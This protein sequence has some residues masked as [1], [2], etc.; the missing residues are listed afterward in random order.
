[1]TS[2]KRNWTENRANSNNQTYPAM[3]FWWRTLFSLFSQCRMSDV[4]TQNQW[5]FQ[6]LTSMH[7]ENNSKFA[8]IDRFCWI[9][10]TSVEVEDTSNCLLAAK[11]ILSLSE[12]ML[13]TACQIQSQSALFLKC[14]EC[15]KGIVEPMAC[16]SIYH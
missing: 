2:N 1:M 11:V 14:Q 7:M 15:K 4:K 6:T 8:L 13:S 9:N 3:I 12:V 10:D 16:I 5:L